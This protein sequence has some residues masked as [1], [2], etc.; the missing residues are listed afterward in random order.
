MAYRAI[1]AQILYQNHGLSAVYDAYALAHNSSSGQSSTSELLDLLNLVIRRVPRSYLVFDGID[2][3]D[4][5]SK[6][7]NRLRQLC[8]GSPV[9]VVLFSRPHLPALR[10]TVNPNQ[11]VTLRRTTLDHDIRIFVRNEIQSLADNNRFPAMSDLRLIENQLVEHAEGMFLWARLMLN[12]LDSP[13]LTKSQRIHAVFESIPTGLQKI[14][15]RIFEQILTL[16]PASQQLARKAFAWVTYSHRNLLD[17]EF[18]EAV[19]PKGM[20]EDDSE[21]WKYVD[22]AVIVVCCGIVEKRPNRAIHFIHLT[23]KE[24]VLSLT[25]AMRLGSCVM[26]AS[27][28]HMEIGTECLRYIESSLP[29]QPLS[30]DLRKSAS[31][32]ELYRLHPILNYAASQWPLHLHRSHLNASGAD[33]EI[34]LRQTLELTSKFLTFPVTVMVWIEA[35]YFFRR[36]PPMESLDLVL[37]DLRN[38]ALTSRTHE[39]DLLCEFVGD[40]GR[41]RQNWDA[42]LFSGSYEIWNEASQMTPSRFFARNH[43]I[44]V[45]NLTPHEEKSSIMHVE[46]LTCLSETNADFSHI[47]KLTIWPS[48][49]V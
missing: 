17:E 49:Y 27:E 26:E 13:A 44:S 46:P 36:G 20:Q 24:Y 42:V 19:Y 48:K 25:P 45:Q 43:G 8:N 22:E 31:N 29:M 15:D 35:A 32:V 37:T 10:N 38:N 21:K 18:A 28:A 9:R 40:L 11:R 4:E 3:C 7:V 23:A 12:Y 1:A 33:V 6:F 5:P 16:D 41:L 47:G 2:E 34:R 30:G 39:M 14:Y